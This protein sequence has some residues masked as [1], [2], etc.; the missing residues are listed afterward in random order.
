MTNKLANNTSNIT[1]EHSTDSSAAIKLHWSF[2]FGVSF[3]I[4]V[5]IVVLMS[6]WYLSKKMVVDEHLPISV[7]TITGDIKYTQRDD[8]VK[9]L[10]EINLAN[11]FQVD[12][13]EVQ[14]QLATLPWVYS[15]SV[16]KQWPDELKIYLV[17]QT[18]IALWN[19]DFLMNQ[20]GNVFQ[21]NIEQLTQ[22]IPQFFGPEGSEN[23][24]LENFNNFNKLLKYNDLSIDELVLSERFS[25]QL[26]LNDGVLLNLGRE[27]RFERIARFID[28]YP[29]IK[30]NRKENQQVDYVDLRYD[31][32]VAVGWKPLAKPMNKPTAKSGVYNRNIKKD[33]LKINV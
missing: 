33:E 7:L 2:W 27:E 4:A 6:T 16:R 30:K 15:V 3:F 18:P 25:W 8:V 20:Y 32:G 21:A 17:D 13:N 29:Q 12:V 11:F 14:Q 5:I 10:A 9:S 26:T 22:K 28:L 19:G 24:A 23:I 31:T 1:A